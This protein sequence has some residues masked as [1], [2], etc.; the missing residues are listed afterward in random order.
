[1]NHLAIL[2]YVL[3]TKTGMCKSTL[4][5]KN[6]AAECMMTCSNSDKHEYHLTRTF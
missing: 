5:F 6:E 4:N 2:Y 3:S 1:M